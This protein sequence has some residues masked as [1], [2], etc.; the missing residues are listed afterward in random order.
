MRRREEIAVDQAAAGV[1]GELRAEGDEATLVPVDDGIQGLDDKERAQRCVLKGGDRG[2]AQT[3]TTHDDIQ[4]RPIEWRQPK[5]GERDFNLVEEA[6]HEEC[7]AEF[8]LEDFQSV[9][10]EDA[11]AA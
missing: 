9:E 6:R 10:R 5:I 8:H 1:G 11:A 4:V 2:V 3:E 7:V